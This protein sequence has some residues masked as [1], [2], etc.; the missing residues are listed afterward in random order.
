MYYYENHMG[1]WYASEIHYDYDDL[2][3]E[4]CGDGDSYIGY[5]E[6]EEEF[7]EDWSEV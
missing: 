3:C 2:Y 7:L 6:T 5:Y 1:G 4:T